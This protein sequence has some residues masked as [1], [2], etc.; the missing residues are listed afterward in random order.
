METKVNVEQAIRELQEGNA[1]YCENRRIYPRQSTERLGEVSA[2]QSPFAV[3]LGCSDS[4]VPPEILFDQGIGDLFVIRV[5]GNVADKTVLGSIEYAADHLNVPL[6][7][8]LGH[9]CCGAVQAACK[10]GTVEGHVGTIIEALK[11]AMEKASC[12]GG[13]MVENTVLENIACVVSQI[14][15]SDVIAELMKAGQLKVVGARYDL[16][17]G[18]VE[19]HL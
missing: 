19:F 5:A 18:K 16:E 8:V 7:V 15:T 6:I 13:D 11:P 12:R 1:R 10:G 14:E 3:I 2:K 17:C 9:G 4:R